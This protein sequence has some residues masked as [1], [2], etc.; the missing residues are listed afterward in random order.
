LRLD[1]PVTYRIVRYLLSHPHASQVEVA[2]QASASRNLVNHVVAQLQAS[3]LAAQRGRMRLELVDPPRL[4]EALSIQRPLSMLA[5]ASVRTEESNSERAE[6]QIRNASAH[7]GFKYALTTFSALSKYTE[8][9]LN[10]PTV[11]VYCDRPADLLGHLP[12]GMGDVTVVVLKPDFESILT[13]ARLVK[14]L[15]VVEPIQTVIDIFG[16]GGGGRDGAIRLYDQEVVH[17]KFEK[18][19]TS[20]RVIQRTA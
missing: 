19:T 13:Q 17:K 18:N 7:S 12:A 8:Y 10:Y 5:L 20:R 15:N 9:Y 2:E 6:R 1:S 11:H 4:L 14:N 3:R 16:L